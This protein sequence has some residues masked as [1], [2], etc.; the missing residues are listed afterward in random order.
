MDRANG[1]PQPA[2]NTG[3]PSQPGSVAPPQPEREPQVTPGAGEQHQQG[4]PPQQGQPQVASDEQ[5]PSQPEVD[6]Q[7]QLQREAELRREREAELRK[8]QDAI[9]QVQKYA[10]EQ[11][12][13]QQLQQRINMTLAHADNLPTS[14]ANTYL[15]NQIAQLV[16]QERIRNQQTVQ[17]LTQQHEQAV[18]QIAAPQYADHLIQSIGLPP[19]AKDE[20]LALRDP[21]LMYQ[22]APVIK[23]RY[24]H[25]NQ[26]RQQWEQQQQQFARTAQA[27]QMRQ[28]GLGAVGGQGAG[29]SYEIEVSDDPD[30]RAMQILAHLRGQE[31]QARSG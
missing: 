16:A 18:K 7:A 25:W 22:Q 11:Q 27:G 26:Q 30:E 13:N 23:Q 5:Q 14:E 3:A 6:Y 8:Y 9:G 29:A 24:D 28:N 12:E 31:R 4:Q 2:V 17:N 15:R 19:E 21:D 20:L 1:N 10:E